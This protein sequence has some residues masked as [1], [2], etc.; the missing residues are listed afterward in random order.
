MLFGLS[1]FLFQ[2]GS[3]QWFVLGEESLDDKGTGTPSEDQQMAHPG[4]S[5][6]NQTLEGENITQV[7]T[8][9]CIFGF[10]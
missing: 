7:S 3:A 10:L 8:I 1:L 4:V 5:N 9:H 6:S 2:E